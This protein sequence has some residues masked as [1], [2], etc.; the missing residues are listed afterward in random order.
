MTTTSDFIHFNDDNFMLTQ[1]DPRIKLPPREISG[2]P[3]SGEGAL[4]MWK[5]RT[6]GA[7]AAEYAVYVN[8]VQQGTYSVTSQGWH[9]M[10]EIVATD[11]IHP[12]NNT[13]GFKIIAGPNLVFGDVVLFFRRDL[14]PGG[15]W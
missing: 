1:H 4:L 13:V 12:G 11:G 15:G 7:S 5:I 14:G 2:T 9:S 8:E 10:H 3:S 6:E